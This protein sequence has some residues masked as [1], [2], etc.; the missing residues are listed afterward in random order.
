MCI[1][2]S[3][4]LITYT[5]G[6]RH[7]CTP[8]FFS[9]PPFSLSIAHLPVLC[10]AVCEPEIVV[11]R[12][13]F[14]DRWFCVCRSRNFALNRTAITFN[15]SL[16]R[17]KLREIQWKFSMST[18]VCRASSCTMTRLWQ[19][20]LKKSCSR[21]MT[22]TGQRETNGCNDCYEWIC[23]AHSGALSQQPIRTRIVH[24]Y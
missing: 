13:C 14:G 10:S 20:C 17:H 18:A 12:H 11:G 15:R 8:S 5:A 9:L 23:D 24:V 7:H 6:K 16:V 1:C 21:T 4:A 2:A 19:T 3:D 22:C